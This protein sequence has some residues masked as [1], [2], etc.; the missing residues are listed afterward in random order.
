MLFTI[1]EW[2]FK[3]PVPRKVEAIIHTVGMI[4]IF[5]FAIFADVLQFIG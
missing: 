1:I 4:L 5:G 2:I 3:K